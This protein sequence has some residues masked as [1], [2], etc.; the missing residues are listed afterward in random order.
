MVLD[1]FLGILDNNIH[2]HKR[3][4]PAGERAYQIPQKHRRTILLE[5]HPI[6]GRVFRQPVAQR[7]VPVE[8]IE[9]AGDD[10][11]QHQLEYS[12]RGLAVPGADKVDIP[13]QLVDEIPAVESAG[14]KRQQNIGDQVPVRLGAEG[15]VA[16]GRRLAVLLVLG[17]VVLVILVLV[18]LRILGLGGGAGLPLRPGVLRGLGSLG[19]RPPS[20]GTR[21]TPTDFWCAWRQVARASWPCGCCRCFSPFSSAI[22]PASA[23]M[24][25]SG[26]WCSLR[27]RRREASARLEEPPGPASR[28]RSC[29]RW[30]PAPGLNRISNI[31]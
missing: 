27:R 12:G 4:D 14:D 9:P 24:P 6:P 8:P 7:I 10:A 5:I 17:I 16:V 31:S 11:Q 26:R 23:A 2:C 18:L 13:R 25:V 29:R 28:R 1:S 20:N 19:P 15:D 3:P 21:G 30:L 22:L